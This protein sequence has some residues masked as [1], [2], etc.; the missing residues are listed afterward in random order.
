MRMVTTKSTP[1]IKISNPHRYDINNPMLISYEKGAIIMAALI[2][3]LVSGNTSG[4]ICSAN[5]PYY[6]PANAFDGKSTYYKCQNTSGTLYLTFPRKVLVNEIELMAPDISGVDWNGRAGTVTVQGFNTTINTWETIKTITSIGF[7]SIGQTKRYS[8]VSSRMY[9]QF[10]FEL[11]SR[12][13]DWCTIGDI[14]LYGN[15]GFKYLISDN[16]GIKTL[17][18]QVPVKVANFGDAPTLE[19]FNQYGLDDILLLTD[20]VLQGFNAPID[21][22]T[23]ADGWTPKM[24]LDAVPLEK[25]VFASDDINLTYAEHINSVTVAGSNFKI[26]VSVDKGKTWHTW[27]ASWQE[28]D[29]TDVIAVETYG[30]NAQTVSSLLRSNW[31]SLFPNQKFA[32]MRV[33]YLLWIAK[34]TDVS[35]T[36]S[37]SMCIDMLGAWEDCVSK[38]DYRSLRT[39]ST[40]IQVSLY[41]NGDYKINY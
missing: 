11:V 33:G 39:S 17:Q 16:E 34:T 29:P 31:E 1:S 26:I 38:T 8:L 35:N 27:N 9:T 28:I 2:P 10:A 4:I 37:M 19:L 40:C 18:N 7:A 3:P 20:Q 15:F 22:L 41:G 24:K 5:N 13:S 32:T 6:E 12:S 25:V 14:Q 36:D 21:I 23:Y 30:M